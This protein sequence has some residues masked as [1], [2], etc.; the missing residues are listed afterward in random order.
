MLLSCLHGLD[1]TVHEDRVRQIWRLVVLRR[2]VR[3]RLVLDRKGGIR[4]HVSGTDSEQLHIVG[5]LGQIGVGRLSWGNNLSRP[6]EVLPNLDGGGCQGRRR[7]VPV[8]RTHE[9]TRIARIVGDIPDPKKGSGLHVVLETVVRF[10]TNDW[11]DGHV[12]LIRERES[13]L[14]RTRIVL[15]RGK[16]PGEKGDDELLSLISLDPDMKLNVGGIDSVTLIKPSVLREIVGPGVGVTNEAVEDIVGCILSLK[17]TRAS[18]LSKILNE[19]EL[20]V[21]SIGNRTI[22]I[23]GMNPCCHPNSPGGITSLGGK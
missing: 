23:L 10:L 4:I 1:D 12:L 2:F 14:E 7:T 21:E 18:G 9:G 20:S 8:G 19:L 15:R 17:D 6:G 11:S 13:V 3:V 5:D 16:I 22:L